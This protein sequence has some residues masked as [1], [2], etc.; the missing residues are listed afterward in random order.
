MKRVAILLTM[1]MFFLLTA[2]AWAEDYP[3]YTGRKLGRGLTNTA[4]GW[5]ELLKSEDNAI[6]KHGPIGA[7]FIG[8]LDGIGN[9]IKRTAVGVYE[10]ATFAVQTSKDADPMIEPEIPGATDRAGYRPKNYTF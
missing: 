10:T 9:T 5:T 4:L 2:A 3:T 8:P 1:G 6:D 7:I